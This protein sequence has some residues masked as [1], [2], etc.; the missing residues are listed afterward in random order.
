M[1][2][3]VFLLLPLNIFRAFSIAYIVD[4]EQVNI[5]LVLFAVKRTFS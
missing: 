2:T 5:S 4:F 1:K 3:P